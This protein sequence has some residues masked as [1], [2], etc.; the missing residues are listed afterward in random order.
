MNNEQEDHFSPQLVQKKYLEL[1]KRKVRP[2]QHATWLPNWTTQRNWWITTNGI[3]VIFVWK[4]TKTSNW[5][6]FNISLHSEGRIE[7][8]VEKTREISARKNERFVSSDGDGW[9]MHSRIFD[10]KKN[11][12]VIINWLRTTI[13]F[14][15][16]HV[17]NETTTSICCASS[18]YLF[19][20]C[21]V[22]FARW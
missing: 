19:R 18:Q 15:Q 8:S 11:L 2:S 16:S 6:N 14:W 17:S 9:I 1:Y 10:R 7:R 21:L 3:S 22:G 20:Q 4:N 13:G 12:Q 5:S